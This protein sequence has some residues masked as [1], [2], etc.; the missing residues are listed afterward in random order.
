MPRPDGGPPSVT[1]PSVNVYAWVL[2][3]A[4]VVAAVADWGAVAT[5]R[6]GVEQL[7][8]PTAVV[9]LLAFAWLL[10]ADQVLAG[11]WLLGALALCLLGDVLLLARSDRAFG[12]GLGAFLLAHLAFL[13]VVVTM[14]HRDP[15]WLGVALT[16]AVVGVAVWRVLWPLAR[17]AVG[18]GAPPT[19]YALVLGAFVALA[20]WSGNL[21]VAV[22]ASLVLLGDAVLAGDRFW[23]PWSGS[24]VAVMVSYHLALAA[25]VLGVLRPD[26]GPW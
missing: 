9:L 17:R 22:G 10:H 2:L 3:A 14:P 7:A 8:K 1:V 16:L 20:W 4:A 24:G 13:A 18:E 6:S 15:V 19:A 26:L 25:L 21:L 11:R 5:R 23:R 12:W